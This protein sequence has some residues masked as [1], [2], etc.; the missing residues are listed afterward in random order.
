MH[1]DRL[2]PD[3]P[4]HAVPALPETMSMIMSMIAAIEHDDKHR[5]HDPS[6]TSTVHARPLAHLVPSFPT[7]PPLES[8]LRPCAICLA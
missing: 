1:T 2:I 3:A 4:V 7:L 8:Q 6:K 5:D